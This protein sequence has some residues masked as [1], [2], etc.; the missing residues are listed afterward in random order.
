MYLL[1]AELPGRIP[2]HWPL[3]QKRQILARQ[4]C[5]F[6]RNQGRLDLQRK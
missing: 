4:L 2:F 5:E 1:S 6:D 3:V